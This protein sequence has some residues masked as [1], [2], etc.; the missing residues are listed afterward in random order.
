MP[1]YVCSLQHCALTSLMLMHGSD[2]TAPCGPAGKP[3]TTG[4]PHHQSSV[5]MPA[6]LQPA[7]SITVATAEPQQQQAANAGGT[8]V[9]QAAAS[10]SAEPQQ[11]HS[12]PMQTDALTA[13]QAQGPSTKPQQ[14]PLEA[15][16]IH[17]AT[18]MPSY[19]S[20]EQRAMGIHA[21]YVV[22]GLIRQ[23]G[24]FHELQQG[25]GSIACGSSSL[26]VHALAVNILGMHLEQKV[27]LP[28]SQRC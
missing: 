16:M 1:Q 28:Q 9:Q 6:S 22:S 3:V 18:W 5:P 10:T 15:L 4:V 21:C 20:S 13:S 7:P 11:L 8:A 23:A 2:L 25:V 14:V 19:P 24:L 26:S 12:D 27:Q 17:P